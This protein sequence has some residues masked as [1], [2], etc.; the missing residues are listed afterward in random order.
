MAVATRLRDGI[1]VVGGSVDLGSALDLVGA[2][3]KWVG[4]SFLVPAAVAVG[5]GESPWP[6]VIG[7]VI[8]AAVG[9]SLDQ[10]TGDKEGTAVG[11]REG[12][13]VIALIW[14]LVPAFGAIPF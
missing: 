12:F 9:W 5:Y 8:T 7:G 11:P 4:A 6:F 2:V 3:L 10:L 1:S 13:L 14:L